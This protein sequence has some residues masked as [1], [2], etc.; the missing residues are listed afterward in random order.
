[1]QHAVATVR[2]DIEEENTALKRSTVG[3]LLVLSSHALAAESN[4]D[5]TFNGIVAR[6]TCFVRTATVCK[7]ASCEQVVR[8]CQGDLC[9]TLSL[10]LKA[11][12]YELDAGRQPLEITGLSAAELGKPLWVKFQIKLQGNPGE[13]RLTVRPDRM[14]GYATS[15]VV[16]FPTNG[17]A[18]GR[19]F[20]LFNFD[21]E[22]LP[23]DP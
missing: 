10:L 19:S 22:R 23:D 20:S 7:A 6:A 18:S 21:C 14:G 16:Y 13:G 1:M 15:A 5:P 3:L 17:D 11:R 4:D 12:T 8:G 9:G 2:I